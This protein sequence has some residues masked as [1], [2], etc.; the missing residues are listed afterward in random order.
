MLLV[1]LLTD[2]ID[3]ALLTSRVLTDFSFYLLKHWRR[4]QILWNLHTWFLWIFNHN[5]ILISSQTVFIIIVFFK[6]LL[7]LFFL[8]IFNRFSHT[9]FWRELFVIPIYILSSK[10]TYLLFDQLP[11][12]SFGSKCLIWFLE[13]AIV[14]LSLIYI[15][16]ICVSTLFSKL[17]SLQAVFHDFKL[18]SLLHF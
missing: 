12:T 14:G 9:Y 17:I 16:L 7:F 13:L 10:F 2:S 8:I 1:F 6:I 11:K 15:I 18:L 5:F 4:L 3:D